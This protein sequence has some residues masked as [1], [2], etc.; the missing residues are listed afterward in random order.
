MTGAYGSLAD[1]RAM[2]LKN[3]TIYDIKPIGLK[4]M[5]LNEQIQIKENT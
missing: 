3:V 1:L 4:K 5:L 2:L